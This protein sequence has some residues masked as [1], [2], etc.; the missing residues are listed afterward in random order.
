MLKT[1]VVRE[2]LPK[3]NINE[4]D[5]DLNTPLLIAARQNRKEILQLLLREPGTN[6]ILM[7]EFKKLQFNDYVTY[8]SGVKVN[9]RDKNGWAALHL[10]VENKNVETVNMLLKA[11]EKVNILI[12]KKCT[13][14]HMAVKENNGLP[15]VSIK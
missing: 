3:H 5:H 1:D 2:L 14:L 11:G 6:L 9:K 12:K 8:L 15:I 13:P 4:L 10:A 7:R